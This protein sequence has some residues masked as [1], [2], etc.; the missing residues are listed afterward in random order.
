[1]DNYQDTIDNM[2]GFGIGYSDDIDKAKE[3]LNNIITSDGRILKEPAHDIFLEELAD[4]SVNFHVRAWA[5]NSD[6][7]AIYNG[8]PEKVKKAFDKEGL[9]I[10]FPQMD[11]HLIQN[12]E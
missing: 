8:L 10:P 9:N 3:I 1:M 12:Q 6:F 4:S 5:K 11:V 2:T 7:W